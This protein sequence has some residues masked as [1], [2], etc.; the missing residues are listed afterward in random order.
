MHFSRQLGGDPIHEAARTGAKDQWN[1]SACG[2]LEG[3]RDSP[4]NFERVEADRYLQQSWQ[5]DYFDFAGFRGR[6]VLEIGIGQ[7]T[8]LLQFGKRGAV[9]HGVDITENHINLTRRNFELHVLPVDIRRMDA[10]ALPFPDAT[11]D[12]VYS[13]GVVHHILEAT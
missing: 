2:Q 9:C 1:A 12:C 3:E 5:H 7:G 13:L 11:F 4:D 8:D 6:N 10:T